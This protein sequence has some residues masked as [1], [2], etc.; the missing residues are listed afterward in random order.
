MKRLRL[1]QVAVLSGGGGTGAKLGVVSF[2]GAV[3]V[4]VVVASSTGLDVDCRP[5]ASVPPPGLI[6]E[7][8]Y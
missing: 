2:L 4:F 8:I 7:N 6:S 3:V 1:E 5:H